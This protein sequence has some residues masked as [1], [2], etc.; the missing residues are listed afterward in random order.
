[1]EELL[2]TI[3]TALRTVASWSSETSIPQILPTPT[4]V[5][6]T[7]RPVMPVTPVTHP[8]THPVTPTTVAFIDMNE[9]SDEPNRTRGADDGVSRFTLIRTL[10]ASMQSPTTA[11]IRTVQRLKAFLRT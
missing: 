5:T 3:P 8:F 2:H 10:I 9:A 6:P 4:Q 7:S 11:D 1:M